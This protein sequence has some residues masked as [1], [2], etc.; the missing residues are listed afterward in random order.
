MPPIRSSHFN[1]N[2]HYMCRHMQIL[3]MVTTT[4]TASPK[5]YVLLW[6]I[7]HIECHTYLETLYI[8]LD[9]LQKL[10]LLIGDTCYYLN[11]ECDDFC[12]RLGKS[13][14]IKMCVLRSSV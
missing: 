6:L 13:N 14:L 7:N 8:Q 3:N 12:D 9:L 2:I 10:Q 4:Q 11:Q 5:I 1:Q